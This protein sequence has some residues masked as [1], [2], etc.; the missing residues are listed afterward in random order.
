LL[1][2]IFNFV[3]VSLAGNRVGR[4]SLDRVCC[5]PFMDSIVQKDK[6]ENQ[7]PEGDRS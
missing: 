1:L 6:D 7:V 2:G 3:S 4:K 5:K